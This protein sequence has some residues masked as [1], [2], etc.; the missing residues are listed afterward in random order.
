M[1]EGFLRMQWFTRLEIV[2]LLY[3]SGDCLL[4]TSFILRMQKEWKSAQ[5]LLVG[6]VQK[7]GITHRRLEEE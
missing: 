5:L 3:R 7:C 6:R 2:M 4:Q 1:E